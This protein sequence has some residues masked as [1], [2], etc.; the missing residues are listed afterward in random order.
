MGAT[1]SFMW[2]CISG[3]FAGYF[4]V[5]YVKTKSLM[6]LIFFIMNLMCAIA[7]TVIFLIKCFNK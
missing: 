6:T 1:Y 4:L 7:Q 3:C 2:M 5:E